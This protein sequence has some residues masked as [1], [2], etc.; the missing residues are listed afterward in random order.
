MVES[1]HQLT[2][3]AGCLADKRTPKHKKKVCSFTGY[4]K[5]G[6][7]MIHEIAETRA[8]GHYLMWR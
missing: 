1:C 6:M 5:S 8:T 2:L 3:T 7:G 4:P